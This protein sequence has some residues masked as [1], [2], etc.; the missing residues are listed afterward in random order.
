LLHLNLEFSVQNNHN[1]EIGE[2]RL[3][4]LLR[5]W[6]LIQKTNTRPTQKASD[7]GIFTLQE[8]V[9]THNHGDKIHTTTKVTGKGQVY[10]V[11]KILKHF[12]KAA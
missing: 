2:K 9:I 12:E 5:D 4:K 3:W 7:M 10:L 11:N 1:V 8:R 6:D